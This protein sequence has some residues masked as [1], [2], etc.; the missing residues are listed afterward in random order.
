MVRNESSD[1]G[2]L[3]VLTLALKPPGSLVPFR[4]KEFKSGPL[5]RKT[6]KEYSQAEVSVK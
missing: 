6:I 2:V 1:I 5:L 4:G 3:A